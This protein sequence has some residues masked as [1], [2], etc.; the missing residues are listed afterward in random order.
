MFSTLSSSPHL[1]V[2]LLLFVVTLADELKNPSLFKFLGVELTRSYLLEH[3]EERYSARR[4]KVYSFMKIPQEVEKFMTYG[5]FQVKLI[6]FLSLSAIRL[7]QQNLNP[8]LVLFQCADS[9][10]FVY[11]FLPMRFVLALVT[12]VCRSFQQCF[13]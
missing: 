11:T 7:M 6:V 3:D 13:G 12:L 10:L 8:A 4:E 5:F 2:I 1:I 9:F